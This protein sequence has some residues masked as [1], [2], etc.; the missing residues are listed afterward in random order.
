MI[1]GAILIQAVVFGLAFV[2]NFEVFA[3]VSSVLSFI[4][5]I[6]CLAAYFLLYPAEKLVSSYYVS[7]AKKILKSLPNLKIIGITGSYGKT[8]TKYILGR[9]LSEKYNT[10]LTPESFNTPMGIVRTVRSEIK[11]QTE[12]FIAEMGAKKRGDIAEI[13]RIAN[14]SFGVITSVGPQHLETFKTLENV[15]NT[16]FELADFVKKNN[17]KL[18]LNTDNEL[19]KSKSAL[20][21]TVS[22]GTGDNCDCKA[23]NIKYSRDGISFDI[24]F[25]GESFSLQSKL[26]GAHSALN[27]TAAVAVA[28]H[29][30][31]EKSDISF[32]VSKLTAVP[33]RL[34][35]KPYIG[36]SVLID[37]AYN[38]NPE[39]CLEAVRILGHFEGMKKIIV[40][41]GLVELGDREYECNR[42]LGEAAALCCDI[43]ILVGAKRSVP[44]SDGAKSANFPQDKLFIA[45]S[46]AAAS[47]IFAPLCDN[48]TVILFEN[49]L[50][51]N[52]IM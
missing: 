2:F 3:S 10:V 34:E 33:H 26:L 21:D 39:G 24:S 11:P 9:I 17:G 52:Y 49:D 30:G 35:M 20:Y 45:E 13:C 48:N 4:S 8:G 28:L 51:D 7:D 31:V 36:G 1:I 47:K 23:Q 43:I 5:P 38:A 46:F 44:L 14:P 29:L 16:K 40:T 25:K 15:A 12:L 6:L 50:P 41:P 22:Y 18:F 27:I 32:A 19:I 42:R 37:D